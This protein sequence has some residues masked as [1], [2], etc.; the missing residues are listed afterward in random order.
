MAFADVTVF[1]SENTKETIENVR[2]QWRVQ[3]CC[4]IP[5]KTFTNQ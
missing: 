1:H 3:S 5:T 4:Q 2:T